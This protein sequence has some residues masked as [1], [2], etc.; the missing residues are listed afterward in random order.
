MLMYIVLL[1]IYLCSQ[2]SAISGKENSTTISFPVLRTTLLGTFVQENTTSFTLQSIQNSTD[3]F[4]MAVKNHGKSNSSHFALTTNISSHIEAETSQISENHSKKRMSSKRSSDN[5]NNTPLP[6]SIIQVIFFTMPANK[7]IP[8]PSPKL[9]SSVYPNSMARVTSKAAIQTVKDYN[10]QVRG[11]PSSDRVSILKHNRS[12][13]KVHRSGKTN[14][15]RKF[16]SDV[17]V[18]KKKRD[19]NLLVGNTIHHSFFNITDLYTSLNP[20]T[21]NMPKNPHDHTT[22]STSDTITTPSTF[23]DLTTASRNIKPTGT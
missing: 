11:T 19:R 21:V 16:N 14:S 8:S 20:Y 1:C 23:S 4:S 10:V 5:I 2:I 3:S 15:E 7:A 12:L 13:M 9:A 18:D 17:N 22:F 6:L